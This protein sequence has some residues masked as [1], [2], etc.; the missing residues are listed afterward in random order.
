[1][2]NSNDIRLLDWIEGLQ[3]RG[4]YAFSLQLIK[5]ELPNYS[6]AGIKRGLNRLS[7]KSKILSIHKGYYIIIPPQYASKGI[8][9]PSLFLDSFMKHLNRPYYL[10]LLNA[11]AYHGAAHQQPQEF[12]VVTNFPVLRTTNKKGIKINYISKKDVPISFTEDRKSEAG[13][14]KISSPVLT[15]VDLIQFEK[16]IG[17]IN[18]AASVLNELSE[19]IKP[20]AFTTEFIKSTPVTTLQ[21]LGYILDK[22]LLKP[23]LANN[24][25]NALMLNNPKFFRIPL[26]TSAPKKGFTSDERWRVI[27]NTQIEIDE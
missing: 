17:G 13:Y 21:R 27:V 1:M 12:F 20:E 7:S 3:S 6:E 25:F 23:V 26:K 9:P 4:K 14:L 18:R 16:R 8:L 11:A 19:V 22:I 5:Q 24:L 10:G 2:T 15:A